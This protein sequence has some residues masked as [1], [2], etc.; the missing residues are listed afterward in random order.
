MRRLDMQTGWHSFLL[1]GGYGGGIFLCFSFCFFNVFTS[2]SQGI[3]QV[4]NI[5]TLLAHTVSMTDV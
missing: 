5:T 2:I 4:P 1:W 3:P